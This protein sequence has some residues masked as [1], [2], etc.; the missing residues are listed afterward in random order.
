MDQLEAEV[1][2][3]FLVNAPYQRKPDGSL[4]HIYLFVYD[5]HLRYTEFLVKY[6]EAEFV[7][8]GFM[9]NWQWHLNI[10]G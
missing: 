8:I 10:L 2:E 4:K 3:S 7:G 6:P 5:H 9:K 1:L